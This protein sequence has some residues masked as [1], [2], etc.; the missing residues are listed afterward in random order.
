MNGFSY[1]GSTLHC[2]GVDLAAL[3]RE[4]GTPLYV[5]SKK[6]LLDNYRAVSPAFN[7]LGPTTVC[8]SVKS[9]SNLSILKLFAEAGAGFDIVSGGELFRVLK[10]GGKPEKTVMAGV[11]KTEK[12][13]RYALEHGILMFNCESE[14]E[15]QAI[16][17]IAGALGKTAGVALR[18]N[19]D[20][21]AHTHAKTTTAKK[22]NKFGIEFSRA[23]KLANE[24]G[25][26]RHV[27]LRG[28]DVHLGS[29]INSLEPYALG[30]ENLLQFLKG[31]PSSI[32]YVDVGGGFGLVYDAEPTPD[33]KEYAAAIVPPLAAAGKKLI[34]E[35]GRSLVGNTAVLL[36]E[37][38]YRKT[39]GDKTFYLTDTGMN[40]L[41]R[42]AMYDAYHFIWPVTNAILPPG[43][44]FPEHPAV[45]ESALAKADV[46]GPICESSDVF[47]KARPL[48]PCERGDLLAIFSAGAYGFSMSSNYNSRPRP[49]EI[50]VDGDRWQTIRR[51]ETWEDLIRGE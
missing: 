36:A 46:T 50:L 3:A 10:A 24:V 41:I 12:E 38:Q 30:V 16:D 28:V 25:K 35:P 48:P 44:L 4:Q 17:A 23:V 8:F 11:A 27:E 39:N 37:I 20:I 45:P 6:A 40:D 9:C 21:D 34:I 22:E 13:I 26:L 47:A 42:P 32:E 1:Q 15:V 18:V 49:A 7:A 33:F 29:P 43:K 31:A 2:E 14:A 19:P 5:Y 51:R